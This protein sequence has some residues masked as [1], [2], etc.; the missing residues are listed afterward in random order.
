[1]P[2][3]AKL[4]PRFGADFPKLRAALEDLDANVVK[5]KVD[6]GESVAVMVGGK[7]H[8]LAADEILVNS[9]P[10]EGLA[11]ASEKGVTVAVDAQITDALKAEGLARELVRRIQDLRKKADFNIEDRI[12]TSYQA[13]GDLAKV[14]SDWADYIRTETLSET[15]EAGEGASNAYAEEMKIE[16]STLRLAVRKA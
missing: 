8:E 7:E 1:M 16:G 6:A 2:D 5:A 13:E 4:G 11:V 12:V 10:G 9:E 15:L 14:F 3:N